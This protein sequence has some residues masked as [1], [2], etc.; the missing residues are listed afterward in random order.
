MR[1]VE[2]DHG[3]V[4]A[5][6]EDGSGRLR[7]TPDIELGRGREVPLG[8]RTA[9]HDDAPDVLGPVLRQITGDVGERARRDERDRRTCSADRSRS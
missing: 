1:D 8:D 9:H 5:A 7:I 2:A 4:Q 6:V 3:H